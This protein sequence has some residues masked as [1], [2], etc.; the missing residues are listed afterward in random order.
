MQRP[1]GARRFLIALGA[2]LLLHGVLAGFV[3]LAARRTKPAPR[4]PAPLVF[5]LRETKRPAAQPAPAQP[6][7]AS[8]APAPAAPAQPEQ[9]AA[10]KPALPHAPAGSPALPAAPA[11]SGAPQAIAQ[12][13]PEAA[14]SGGAAG[15]GQ[16]ASG[17]FDGKKLSLELSPDALGGSGGF[18]G[19]PDDGHGGLVV[20]LTPEQKLADEKHVV[21]GR[22]HTWIRDVSARQRAESR[23]VYWQGLQDKLAAGPKV[24]WEILDKGGGQIPAGARIASQAAQ[25]WQRAAAAYGRGGNPF[26]EGGPGTREALNTEANHLSNDDRG[27]R[28]DP[29]LGNALGAPLA[30]GAGSGDGPFAHR[31]VVFLM[32]TQAADGSILDV[33]VQGGSGNHFYDDLAL[34]QARALSKL[35]LG[36]PPRD[37]TQSLWAFETDFTQIPPL[38]IFGCALDNFIPKDCYYPLKKNVK[39]RWHLEAVY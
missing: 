36:I 15:T 2:A 20:E 19:P 31:L 12:K 22:L 1:S 29:S 16:G 30:L 27:F 35:T 3:I 24:Q 6:A 23:D 26:G 10:K 34:T 21:E 28:G 4:K 32:I 39:S 17:F 8:S 7:P 14:A 18:K 5:E 33:Q 38:P 13:E 11:A 37:H 25:Q 9:H